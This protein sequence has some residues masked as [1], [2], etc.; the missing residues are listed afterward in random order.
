MPIG[1]LPAQDVA[2]IVQAMGLDPVGPPMRSGP[3]F[4]QRAS[5]DFGRV[6]RVTVDARR[7]QVIAIE[8]APR[9]PHGMQAGYPYG[10][11]YAPYG[12]YP[13][14]GAVVP[15]YDEG[16]LAPPGSIRA[17]RAQPP[18]IQP[19]HQAAA[20]PGPASPQTVAPRK[21]A[22]KSAAVPPLHPPLPR[23]RPA[24][25][26]QETAGSVEPAPSQDASPENSAPPTAAATA[27]P[28]TPGKPQA[29]MPPVAPLE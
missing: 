6:L 17:P 5:D 18:H 24:A 1:A 29:G 11:S 9:A 12:R 2:E 4:V 7:S 20:T 16:A 25:A 8:A 10:G 23:K 26:P 22:V 28:A 3:F 14:Y 21:P 27:V 15:D 19:L 13:V